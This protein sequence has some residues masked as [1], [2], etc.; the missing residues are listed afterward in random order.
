MKREYSRSTVRAEPGQGSA[1]FPPFP[2]RE[3][4]EANPNEAPNNTLTQ[5]EAAEFKEVLLGQFEEFEK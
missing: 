2:H 4:I 5:Q 1:K 3:R